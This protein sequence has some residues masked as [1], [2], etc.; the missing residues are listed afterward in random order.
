MTDDLT[1]HASNRHAA[2]EPELQPTHEELLAAHLPP[3]EREQPDPVLQLS[4]GRAGAGSITLVAV[5][6][7]IVIAVVFY[8]LNSPAPT[9]EHAPA[10]P[11][12]SSAAPAA[13][14]GSGAAS[15]AAAHP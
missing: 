13:G 2:S 15:G 10:S 9:S 1:D 4:V 11:A 6:A 5:V 8:G 3:Q 7:A 14:G 12:A